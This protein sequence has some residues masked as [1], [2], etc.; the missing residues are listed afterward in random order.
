VTERVEIGTAVVPTPVSHPFALG[1][2]AAT[3]QQACGGRFTLG[4][5]LSHKVMVE[6][7]LGMKFERPVRQMREYLE[8]LG[9][10]LRGEPVGYEGEIYTA[11]F[12]PLPLG[13]PV[14]V[15]VAAL[16]PQMLRLTGRLADGTITW[17]SGLKT[18]ENHIVPEISK[19]AAA[20]GRPLPR[21]VAGFPVVVT[22]DR[23][24]ARDAA[25]RTFGHYKTLPSYRAM[26]DRE[27]SAGVEDLVIA[28]DEASVRAQLAR[29]E[30]TGT[31]DLCAFPFAVDEGSTDRTL[32]LLGEVARSGRAD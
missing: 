22:S 11:R 26:L 32:E 21:V 13:T 30:A 19:S 9:P 25:I 2:Q 14:S 1:N 24:A 5:G 20:A 6:N 28:G 4:I 17:A 12:A 31:T 23:D 8:V 27:G 16:G 15:L 18:L 29:I 3:A 10:M 7:V